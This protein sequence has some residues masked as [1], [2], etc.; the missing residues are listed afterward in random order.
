MS[1]DFRYVQLSSES[2]GDCCNTGMGRVAVDFG[3]GQGAK[4][5]ADIR[6]D[7]GQASNA[8]QRQNPRKPCGAR[9]KGCWRRRSFVTARY[10]DAPH[11]LLAICPFASTR[12]LFQYFSSLQ[13]SE[14]L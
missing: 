2:L 8:G 11:S 12:D 4:G 6:S 1:L 13:V 14:T 7:L 3:V 9:Q 10:W 5:S